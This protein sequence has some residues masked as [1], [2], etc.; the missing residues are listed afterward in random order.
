MDV[1]SY[2]SDR[3]ISEFNIKIIEQDLKR[4]EK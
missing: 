3:L 2:I 4:Y 1:G